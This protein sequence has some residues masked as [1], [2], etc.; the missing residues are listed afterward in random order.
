M[1]HVENVGML[2]RPELRDQVLV[3]A[4][5]STFIESLSL[6]ESTMA[7]LERNWDLDF[8]QV[9]RLGIRPCPTDVANIMASGECAR[10]F[11]DLLRSVPGF[12]SYDRLPCVC[13]DCDVCE[14]ESIHGC[15]CALKTWRVDL[16]PKLSRNGIIVPQRNQ[17]G[18]ISRLWI[19]RHCGD[20]HPFPLAVRGE[21][22]A[23]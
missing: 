9:E 15:V 1:D 22:V 2:V 20:R 14:F 3:A 4:V 5:Y 11:G 18:W 17:R 7:T 12:F 13:A 10:R 23:A 21:V 19:F 8:Q 6:Y 16:R